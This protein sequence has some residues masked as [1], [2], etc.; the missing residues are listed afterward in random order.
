[1]PRDADAAAIK[2]ALR[3]LALK[4][5]PDRNKEPG[6]EERFKEI[7]AAYA[8][9]SDPKKRAEYDAGGFGAAAGFSPEDL[10]G[11]IDFDDLFGG[12][13]LGFGGSLF[14]RLFRHRRT[15]PER[16]RD[17]E[18]AITVPLAK[19]A[20]GGEETVR[21]LRLVACQACQGTGAL[22][23]T[24]PRR[25]EACQG[26]GRQVKSTSQAG[27]TVQQV[28]TCPRCHG[29]GHFIDQPCPDCAGS[30]QAEHTE[31]VTVNIPPGMEEG[32]ALRVPG[33]GMP[34]EDKG[35]APVRLTTSQGRFFPSSHCSATMRRASSVNSSAKRAR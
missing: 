7:A 26:S 28:S 22:A 11:G 31:S 29:R 27:V 15:G 16:G 30:G 18:I 9:L 10:F 20:S 4:Y 2:D 14:D 33:H 1:M 25:C 19:I 17:I 6:A 3:Q 5:H 12:M 24:T 8:V 35:G 32:M 13:G 34:S 23:G 21:F